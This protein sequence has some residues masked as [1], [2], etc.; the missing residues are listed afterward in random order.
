MHA[1]GLAE[2][3]GKVRPFERP[4]DEAYL[5]LLRTTQV[6]TAPV[7]RM[8]REHGLS[9]AT[10][11]VLRILRGAGKPGLPSQEIGARMVARV[12]DVT[13]LVDRLQDEGL[14]A[15]GRVATDR[16]IVLV[17][18]TPQGLKLLGALDDPA[19]ELVKRLLGHLTRQELAE[20]NRLL[21]KAR[22]S[23]TGNSGVN[24]E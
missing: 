8:F 7:E 3:I 4:E 9:E 19:T 2:E 5:N 18:I 20:L 16:R 1:T 11:N 24:M 12:P 10:Y 6:L 23:Q 13:R 14:V 22:R 21:V 15:R 17:S